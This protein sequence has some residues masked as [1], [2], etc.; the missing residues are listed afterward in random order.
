M[1]VTHQNHFLQHADQIFAVVDGTIA[2]QGTYKQLT[3][4]G[5]DFDSLMAVRKTGPAAPPVDYV[6][7][8]GD[9]GSPSMSSLASPTATSAASSRSALLSKASDDGIG[10]SKKGVLVQAE[11]RETGVVNSA[12]YWSYIKANGSALFISLY[13]SRAGISTCLLTHALGWA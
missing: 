12:V 1:F 4:E 7:V 2:H 10:T 3:E 5:V 6:M 13:A 11:E 8:P 9:E